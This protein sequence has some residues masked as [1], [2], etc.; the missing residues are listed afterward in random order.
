MFKIS[1]V[2][3]KSAKFYNPNNSDGI[4]KKIYT[5]PYSCKKKTLYEN[6]IALAENVD[7]KML[8]TNRDT[9]TDFKA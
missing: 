7:S 1:I 2:S 9:K 3:E 5:F 6:F 4:S 8:V